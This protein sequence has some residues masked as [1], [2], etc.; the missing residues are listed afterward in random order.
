MIDR[1]LYYVSF[2]GR[3]WL[4]A[5]TYIG[6]GLLISGTIPEVTVQAQGQSCDQENP[7]PSPYVCCPDT[8]TCCL[9]E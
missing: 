6:A 8:G 5:L 7:C 4:S 2:R 3:F 1:I 9:S